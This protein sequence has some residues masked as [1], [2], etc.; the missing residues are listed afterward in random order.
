M[1]EVVYYRYMSPYIYEAETV[2]GAL[3]FIEGGE[4]NGEMSSVGVFRDGEPIIRRGYVD[5]DPPTP[6]QADDM[7]ENYRRAKARL[8]PTGEAHNG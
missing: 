1:I 3:A 8:S 4:D 2:E 7:R 6:K 5:Q